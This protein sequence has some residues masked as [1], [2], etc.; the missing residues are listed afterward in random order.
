MT[1]ENL[2]R[3]LMLLAL[4]AVVAWFV[5]ATEWVEE[6]VA[7][8][9]RGEAAKNPLYAAQAL[10]RGLGAKVVRKG[11]VTDM[12]P[13]QA[14]LV[15][16]ASN[17]DLF[18]ERAKRIHSWV[19]NGGQLVIPRWAMDLPSLEDLVFIDDDDV[20]RKAKPAQCSNL[21]EVRASVATRARI[22]SSY[23]VCATLA[24]AALK[25]NDSSILWAVRGTDGIE[26][27]RVAA[28]RG[29]ITV[30]GPWELMDNTHLLRED[31]AQLT[32][33]ALQLR[34]GGEIW[35]VAEEARTGFL[36][37]LWQAAWPALLLGLL[38]I[39]LALWRSSV[40]FGAVLEPIGMQRRSMTEQVLGTGQFLHQHGGAALHAAA[41]HALR[42]TARARIHNFAVQTLFEQARIL[43]SVT[44]L[45]EVALI[46]ALTPLKSPGK[47]ALAG[48]LEL[49]ETARRRLL[50]LRGRAH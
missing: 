46:R 35:F 43:S 11:G 41:I 39:A 28:G 17:W 22:Q 49:L 19:R 2:L 30:V 23:R 44:G 4:V 3:A 40:R 32:A 25:A 37:W 36:P 27:L 26:V 45:A 20:K 33:D 34:A 9:P 24:G 18:P 8:P 21:S 48:Q 13:P 38:A 5:S 47:Q 31:N 15:L 14:T 7:L 1:R 6:D 29:S 42:E 10:A 16:T 12:P 50:D